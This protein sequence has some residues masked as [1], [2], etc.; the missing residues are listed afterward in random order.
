MKVYSTSD[1]IDVIYAQIKA[2][3]SALRE[4]YLVT[5]SGAALVLLFI[6]ISSFILT[7]PT[8]SLNIRQE[9]SS[10]SES[11]FVEEAAEVSFAPLEKD[12]PINTETSQ[13]IQVEI[14]GNLL[15]VTELKFQILNFDPNY[16]YRVDFGNGEGKRVSETF[17]YSYD[18][19]GFFELK[20]TAYGKD[21]SK[22]KCK[23]T[24]DIRPWEHA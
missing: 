12:L 10:I 4:K 8:E 22:R 3:E 15:T 5:I 6:L 1:R 20:I 17:T 11:S 16:I 21:N 2:Q 23:Q 14:S 13:P 7:R 18:E 19:P 24:L 9:Q